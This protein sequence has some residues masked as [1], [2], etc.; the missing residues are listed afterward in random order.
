MLDLEPATRI[1]QRTA[2]GI[3]DERLGA[4]TPCD[5]SVEKLLAHVLGLSVAFREAARKV[6][7]PSTDAA[8][9]LADGV[10][11]PDWRA[12]LPV[13]LDELA[14]AWREPGAWE[15]MT[16]AGGLDLPAQV[17]GVVATNE[18]V[19]HGWDLAAATGQR[20]EPDPA[21][22]GAS[23][24]MVSGTPDD[25]AARQGLFGPVV[26][27]PADAPLLDRVLGGAG[28]DPLWSP[29]A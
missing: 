9:S 5:V 28:R 4:T 19:L 22:L 14:R 26:P 11:P 21:S 13:V 10:L 25:P 8:P 20:Y 16:R 7:G 1:L 12:Q 29:P 27:V 17:A 23:W 6:S 24:Q 18:L 2:D 3:A 15:G